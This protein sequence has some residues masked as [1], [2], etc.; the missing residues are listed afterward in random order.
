[1]NRH[2]NVRNETARLLQ[3]RERIHSVLEKRFFSPENILYDYA[4]LNGETVIPTP[5]ECRKNQPNPFAWNTPIENGAFFNGDLLTGLIDLYEKHPSE[6]LK[7]QMR[8]LLAGL[9]QLHDLSPVEGCILRGLASDGKTAYPAS[10]NDQVIPWLLGVWSYARSSAADEKEKIECR[11]RCFELCRA[12]EKNDWNIPGLRPG[13]TRG[14][15]L[16]NN[17]HDNC[18]IL[19]C[20]MILDEMEGEKNE[21][22]RRIIEERRDSIAAGWP[23]IKDSAC[24]YSA[25]NFYIMRLASRIHPECRDIFLSGLRATSSGAAKHLSRWKNYDPSLHFSPDWHGLNEVWKEQNNSREGDA[26]AS[27]QWPIWKRDSPITVN[28][29]VSLRVA[30]SAAWIIS[31][32]ENQDVIGE[33]AVQIR[34]MLENI[35]YEKLHY[36]TFFFAENV[37]AGL[38][39]EGY[40]GFLSSNSDQ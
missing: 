10:S 25:H 4:G 9:F 19:L 38:I 28:E 27:C 16:V 7:T 32:S 23:E 3:L 13:F 36:A 35:P 24:W 30:L 14:R 1:M 26:V 12:L 22:F 37:I 11:E 5:E 39:R 17:P 6:R 8:R 15:L 40:D 31:F 18:H 21:R 33:S 2:C 34:E 29:C 20:A